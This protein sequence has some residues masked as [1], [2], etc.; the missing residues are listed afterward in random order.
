MFLLAILFALF[1]DASLPLSSG[2]GEGAVLTH[3]IALLAL[4]FDSAT[5][6][7]ASLSSNFD[8][9]WLILC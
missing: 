4:T 5:T 2:S 9:E 1:A 3:E 7:I 8:E 6:F